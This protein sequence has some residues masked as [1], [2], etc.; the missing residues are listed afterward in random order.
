[1]TDTGQIK[2]EKAILNAV[3]IKFTFTRVRQERHASRRRDNPLT[4][5]SYNKLRYLQQAG[6]P[7]FRR[8]EYH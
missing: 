3:R 1:M 5:R 7:L 4:P 8:P 6:K 2:K